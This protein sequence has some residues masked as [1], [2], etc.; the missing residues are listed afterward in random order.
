MNFFPRNAA[1]PLMLSAALFTGCATNPVTGKSELSLVPESQEILMGQ[2]GAKSTV[3]AIGLVSSKPLQ[4]YVS[5]LGQKLA[6]TSERPELPWAF[7]VIDDPAVNAFAMPGGSI[8]ITRGILSYMNSEA[9]LVSVL[10]HEIGHVAAKHSVR[11]ISRSQLAQVGLGVTSIMA[12][13]LAGVTDLA[14]AGL[15]LLFLKFGR[16][17][18]LQADDLGFQYTVQNGYDAREMASMFATLKRTETTTGSQRLPEWASTHPD[19]DNRIRKTDE[20]V[21]A[22]GKDLRGATV[23]RAEFLRK[24]DGLMFGE[25][26]RAGYFKGTAFY[27]P[28][29]AFSLEFPNGWK[30]ANQTD[31]VVGLSSAQDAVLALSLAG[32]DSADQAART[33]AT[34]QGIEATAPEPL[35]V[36]GLRAYTTSFRAQMQDGTSLRGMATFIEHAD[37]TYRILGYTTTNLFSQYS[38]SIKETTLSFRRVTDAAV[39]NAKPAVVDL[40]TLPSAMT[41]ER[42]Y[43]RYPSSVPIETVAIINGVELG[44]TIAAGTLVKRVT[45]GNLP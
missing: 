33:F 7:Y 10:G 24:T 12:P 25:N 28:D 40:V 29:L 3:E 22:L 19:P 41:I 8:F 23:N 38:N 1:L 18:E 45:G 11:Q 43:D 2:E 30:T 26:P 6:A 20:R 37:N 4:D 27:H 13:Q 36:H 35:S 32:K 39:L 5:G 9:E 15:G 14:A 42:F 21:A 16:G 17:D 44:K 34:Q 31:S